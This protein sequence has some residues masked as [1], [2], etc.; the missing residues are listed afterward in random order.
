METSVKT[1]KMYS[2]SCHEASKKKKL[3][4]LCARRTL[5]PRFGEIKTKTEFKKK[6]NS[7]DFVRILEYSKSFYNY[8]ICFAFALYQ[9]SRGFL[10]R[11]YFFIRFAH[12]TGSPSHDV[13]FY[14]RSF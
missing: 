14:Y 3:L 12:I 8:S 7:K 2:P 1:R 4:I 5:R 10:M 13:I 9:S 11:I 6:K